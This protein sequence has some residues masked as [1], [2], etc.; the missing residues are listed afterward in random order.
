MM[1]TSHTDVFSGSDF[2]EKSI[3]GTST[4]ASNWHEARVPVKRK[5]LD[6]S[7]YFAGSPVDFHTILKDIRA[8]V[9]ME[10]NAGQRGWSTTATFCISSVNV[11][12]SGLMVRPRSGTGTTQ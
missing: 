11:F 8:G 12:P 4:W 5:C 9:A 1:A 3:E 10:S 7:S 2:Q 6:G